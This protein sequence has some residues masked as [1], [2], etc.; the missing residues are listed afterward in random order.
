MKLNIA[1]PTYNR[2]AYLRRAIESILD[3]A[4]ELPIGISLSV[5]I[6][7]NLSS[8]DTPAICAD[9][10]A[11]EPTLQVVRHA[12]NIGGDANI[13]RGLMDA[14]GDYVWVLGDDDYLRSG[15]LAKLCELLMT[16]K[17]DVIKMGAIEERDFKFGIL[18]P[19]QAQKSA[20]THD[21][22]VENFASPTSILNRF[23]MSLG[24]FSTM[25]FARSFFHT[26]YQTASAAL[27]KSGYSQLAWI[28][29][30]LKE[31]S[32]RFGFIVEPLL[33]LRIEISP[34]DVSADQVHVGLDILRTHLI[35]MDYPVSTVDSFH[36]RQLD[37]I[38]LGHLKTRKMFGVPIWREL[39]AAWAGLSNG[40]Q[41]AKSLAIAAMPSGL[42]RWL[43]VR[44]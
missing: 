1:I 7:D 17:F 13:L 21:L 10:Q 36:S 38:L 37:A 42:Y 33:V 35:S 4:D 12:V 11:R 20:L 43:W 25:I 16:R 2:G 27:F 44:L 39:A 22:T 29:R 28:Y 31:R 19:P 23:G 6:Y 30:G 40:R 32:T 15:T 34:R 24:N 26:F 9:L 14:D 8:D 18:T 3:H 41:R 5:C